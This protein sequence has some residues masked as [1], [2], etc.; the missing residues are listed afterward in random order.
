MSDNGIARIKPSIIGTL[1]ALV[2]ILY[3]FGMGAGFGLCEEEIKDYLKGEAAAVKDTVYKGDEV[4][5]KKITDKSWVYLK[6]AHLHAGVLGAI[7][8][9]VALLL[10]VLNSCSLCKF[11]GSTCLG[12]GAL[13]YSVFWML[14]GATAPALGDTEIAKEALV[15]LAQPSA[16]LCI[17]GLLF[18]MMALIKS[19]FCSCS[20]QSHDAS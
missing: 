5:M 20:C 10:G 16:V 17:A 19:M 15:W 12:L 18:A 7:A 1:L 13:G 9:A 11:I 3:S 6:R 8:L 14:A 2:T 4:K